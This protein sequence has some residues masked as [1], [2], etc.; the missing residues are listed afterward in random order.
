M[1]KAELVAKMGEL[2][3]KVERADDMLLEGKITE[4]KHSEMVKRFEEELRILKQHIALRQ[5]K[6][7]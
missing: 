3:Q 2:E 6:R 4:T 5:R 7:E 1:T